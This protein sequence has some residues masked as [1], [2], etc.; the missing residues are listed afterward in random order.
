MQ[1]SAGKKKSHYGRIPDRGELPVPTNPVIMAT[2]RAIYAGGSKNRWQSDSYGRPFYRHEARDGRISLFF[3]SPPDFK[4]RFHPYYI[5]TPRMDFVY[6]GKLRQIVSNLSVET[7]DIFLILMSRIAGLANP[8]NGVARIS[9]EEIAKLRGV[10][11][12]HGRSRTLFEDFRQEVL[13]LSDMRLTL[14][15]KDYRGGGMVS[16]GRE[17]PDRLLDILDM[18]HEK[19]GRTWMAFRFRCGQALSHFLDPEGLRWIGY[20][21]RSLLRLNPYTSAFT[22]KLGTYWIMLG[23]IAGKKGQQPAATPRT[24]LDFCSEAIHG[25]APGRTVDAFIRSHEELADIGVLDTL[26]VLEPPDRGRGYFAE[27]LDRPLT[28]KLSDHLWRIRETPRTRFSA[29][30]RRKREALDFMPSTARELQAN[31]SLIRQLRAEQRLRQEE[32]ASSLGVTRQTLSGYER[33]L[34]PLPEDKAIVLLDLWQ[35][36]TRR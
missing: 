19:D 24:I 3:D 5:A 18:E 2:L 28:V 14:L 8:V 30:R 21:S 6:S 4:S 34:R 15:W 20:Y 7:A 25:Q 26:P 23:I 36:S 12:R 31:P 9:L 11:L 33:G 17:R 32:L 29:K 1:R 35:R 16:L 13:R 10:N 27:W 22:K